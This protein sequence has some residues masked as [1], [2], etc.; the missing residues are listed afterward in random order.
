MAAPLRATSKVGKRGV[1]VIPAPLRK[2]F[3]IEEGAT[4]IAEERED[5]VLIRPAVTLPIEI[6]TDE[7]IAEF[8]LNNSMPGKDYER[9]RAEVHAMGLDPDAIPHDK[10]SGT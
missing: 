1:V 9:A 7:R 5:G 4:V 3:G 8:I 10:P 6:Y 2:R